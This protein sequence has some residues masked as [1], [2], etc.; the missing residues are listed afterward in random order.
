MSIDIPRKIIDDNDIDETYSF[1]IP[2]TT[3]T[4]D[5]YYTRGEKSRP[6]LVHKAWQ[7]NAAC[8]IKFRYVDASGKL[9][10]DTLAPELD[11]TR[12]KLGVP[13]TVSYLLSTP[14]GKS[15]DESE[16]SI[17]IVDAHDNQVVHLPTYK[18]FDKDETADVRDNMQEVVRVYGAE[19]V[20]EIAAMST[21]GDHLSS[22][23]LMRAVVQSAMVRQ[24]A[25]G[26]TEVYLT[27]LTK[28][29]FRPIIELVGRNAA[30]VLGRSVKI[31]QEDP[32]A[33][34]DLSVTPVLFEPCRI[35]M[36]IVQ[37]IEQ[38]TDQADIDRLMG[39][40]MF[41]NDGLTNEQI[42]KPVLSFLKSL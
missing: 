5:I 23:E 2:R 34:R 17:R 10:D 3:A 37:E 7:I 29:S 30:H 8:Y 38:A 11:G 1:D 25:T 19:N 40:L 12:E 41:F 26:K 36:G 9:E 33:N 6:D 39:K 21:I 42:G 18:Y 20:R 24:A 32:R 35:T 15:I 28:L 4:Y 13:I 16:G 27:S 22:Y 31:H 14:R